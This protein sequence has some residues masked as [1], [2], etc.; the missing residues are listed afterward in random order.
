M[1]QKNRSAA[2][3][4]LGCIFALRDARIKYIDA[5]ESKNLIC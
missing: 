2:R 3:M 1:K 4:Q 5:R